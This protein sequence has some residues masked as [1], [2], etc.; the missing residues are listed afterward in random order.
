M[1][2]ICPSLIEWRHLARPDWRHKYAK[3]YYLIEEALA[4]GLGDSLGAARRTELLPSRSHVLVDAVDLAQ[5]WSC[6]LLAVV[7]LVRVRNSKKPRPHLAFRGFKYR[8]LRGH[9]T[10]LNCCSCGRN[11]R[12]E[13]PCSYLGGCKGPETAET[14]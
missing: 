11:S 5:F 7:P 1:W 6:A 8:W 2:I 3:P 10:I 14:C 13:A 9:A 4:D 12:F